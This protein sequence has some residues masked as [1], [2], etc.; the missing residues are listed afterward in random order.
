MNQV[1]PADIANLTITEKLGLM[2]LL[3]QD[4]SRD[5]DNVEVPERH[6]RTLEE[7]ERALAN[8]ETAFVDFE[9]AMS[10][11]RSRMEHRRSDK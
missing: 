10:N 5:P 9:E 2:E 7:R 11:I 6:L 3:W 8:G 4:I 1:S